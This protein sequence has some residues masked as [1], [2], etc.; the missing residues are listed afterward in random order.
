MVMMAGE[1]GTQLAGE[2]ATV[3][4]LQKEGFA[5]EL[6]VMPRAGHY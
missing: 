3:G 4:R 1:L 2:R 6:I 5:A